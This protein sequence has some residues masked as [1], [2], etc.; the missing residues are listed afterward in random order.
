M[1]NFGEILKTLRTEK[2]Y[3]QKHVA[4]RVGLAISA[5]SSYESRNRFPTYDVIVKFA[6]IFHI[7]TDFLL[8]MDEV[9]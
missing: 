7:S 4:D 3:T 1:V 5:I 9:R 8:D 6:R 2:G